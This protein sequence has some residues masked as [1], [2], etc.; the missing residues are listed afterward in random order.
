[1]NW[2]MGII[3]NFFALRTIKKIQKNKKSELEAAADEALANSLRELQSTGKIA[4][5]ILKAK[6]ISQENEKTLRKIRELDEEFDDDEE[7]E[8]EKDSIED[9]LIKGLVNKFL[10][11]ASS[12]DK[13]KILEAAKN[14]SPEQLEAIKEKFLK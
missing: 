2:T 12:S 9:T 6:L 10:G 3:R 4:D 11:G 8:E 14:L 7:E 5:K 13:D 1:M